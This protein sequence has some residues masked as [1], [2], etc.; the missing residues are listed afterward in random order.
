MASTKSAKRRRR[1][2]RDRLKN[3]QIRQALKKSDLMFVTHRHIKINWG[4][5]L[6]NGSLKDKWHDEGYA[7]G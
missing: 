6:N 5:G 4:C 3:K 1:N 2:E 7:V